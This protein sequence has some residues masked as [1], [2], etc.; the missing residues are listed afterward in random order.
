MSNIVDSKTD[1]V[2]ADPA[3]EPVQL[4]TLK[5]TRF[6]M[7]MRFSLFVRA[8]SALIY[9][10]VVHEPT[11]VQE[12]LAIPKDEAIVYLL[13]SE[14]KHDY[15][16]LNDLCLQMGMP[17]AYTGNG[18]SKLRYST[19]GRRILGLFSKRK[20][21]PTPQEIA[22]CIVE[23]RPILIFLN[24]YGIF[25]SRN[26]RRTEAIFDAIEETAKANN[27]R[28][29]YIPVGII[30]ERRAETYRHTLFNELY[31][32]PTKPSSIRRFLSVLPSVLQLFF[33]IGK[34]LCLIHHI[35]ITENKC[36]SG[37]ELRRFLNDEI[38]AMHTQVNGP[39][40]KPHQQLLREIIESSEFQQE[41]R[42]IS[43]ET[44]KSQEE[45][46][47]EARKILEKTA[48]KFSLLMCKVFCT[49]L[50]PMWSTVY[51]G[52][53]YDS[54]KLNELRELSKTH[55]LVFIPSHKSH[56]DY[57]VLSI[58]LFQNGVLPPHI[59][60]GENLNFSFIGGILRRG[61]AFFIKRSFKGELLYTACIKHYIAKILHEG[62]P[63]EFF[64][65][66]GRSRT[67]QVL[68]PKYGILRMIAQAVQADPNL[69]VKI[70]P[71]AIT[72]EKVI[73]D[74]AYKN[75]QNG[76]AKQKENIT[77]LIR[78]TK[79]LISKYGQIYLS[80]GEPIDLNDALHITPE[81]TIN[82]EEM[83]A[84]IDSMT[85]ELMERINRISTVTTSALLTCALLNAPKQPV[86][87]D[88]LM[89][90]A[91]FLLA[92][93]IDH[94]ALISPVL[95]T[96]LAASRASLYE[97]Q[98]SGEMPAIPD[99]DASLNLN[100]SPLIEPLKD[101]IIQTIKLFKSN[102]TITHNSD[103][104]LIEI[105]DTQRLQ[106]SFY[107]NILLFPLIDDIYLSCALRAT[108]D[109]TKDAIQAR[110][111]EIADFFSIEFLSDKAQERAEQTLQTFIKRQW[112]EEKSDK[113]EIKPDAAEAI[114]KLSRCMAHHIES[115][116]CVYHAF[117]KLTD[118]I[119]ESKF[120]SNLLNA[121]VSADNYNTIPESRSKVI[122][123]HGI[124]K[125][126]Q[127]KI[128]EAFFEQSGRKHAKFLKRINNLTPEIQNLL[129]DISF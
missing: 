71:C 9:S 2:K 79:L 92:L 41:L 59:A 12:I 81:H 109:K 124:Q 102:K 1:L 96:T 55:R 110:F 119:E 31:G 129:K 4:D 22:E 24:Q 8:L 44:S 100:V 42:T 15:L 5:P 26:A 53:Y 103:M 63:V 33:Q 104:S 121:D 40:V 37:A 66:G 108:N 43:Q 117:E 35:E 90:E 112:L 85:V 34:P 91:A 29:H 49:V 106:I 47:I 98:I 50:T 95:Q 88:D 127:Q 128:A 45:L 23:R 93:L 82:D 97:P 18:Q 7:L 114:H 67:G 65:E 30:W 54:E 126:Q 19:L 3:Q 6:G 120:I 51:N 13:A 75:E 107:K 60:A 80:F 115:Y 113:I 61:G 99:L 101:P 125:L 123:S 21:K 83:T 84:Y 116:Q 38:D 62:Y 105:E 58:I 17:L 56:I 111:V 20:H 74:M 89:K 87:F 14:N 36:S 69:P 78:T 118:I 77:N 68:Q 52:L 25:E 57:L 76:A 86:K 16:F 11:Q 122:Y 28:V 73:E 27:I 46:S 39:K 72:Y 32:T 64:I 70:I 10:R 94:N 48:S